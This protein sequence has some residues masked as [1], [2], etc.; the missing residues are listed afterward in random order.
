MK[1]AALFLLAIPAFSA[2]IV[3]LYGHIPG[4]GFRLPIPD[5]QI[6]WKETAIKVVSKDVEMPAARLQDLWANK[7]GKGETDFNFQTPIPQELKD[8]RHYVI[9]EWGL[10]PLRVRNL[11]GT[12]RYSFD[13]VGTK[14]ELKKVA[15]GGSAIFDTIPE[16]EYVEGA[17]AWIADAP[18]T[19]ESVDLPENSLKIVPDGAATLITYTSGSTARTA[20]ITVPVTPETR[21]TALRTVG[22]ERY[23]FLQWERG[24]CQYTFTLLKLTATGMDEA[25]SNLYGCEY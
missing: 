3:P 4:G 13:P 15:F 23:I 16:D 20:R 11:V 6:D 8:R 2:E 22:E 5:A 17:F 10:T 7:N 24:S 9:S 14:P 12:I 1:F 21:S 18:V 19:S 25:A